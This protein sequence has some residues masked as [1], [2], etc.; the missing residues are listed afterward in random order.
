M[1]ASGVRRAKAAFFIGCKSHPAIAPAGSNRSSP[2]GDKMAEAFG[3]L[4]PMP[5][6]RFDARTRRR[7]PVRQQRTPGSVRG[8]PGARPA[9][10][11]RVPEDAA[12]HQRQADQLDRERNREH[13]ADP[14][15]AIRRSRQAF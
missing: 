12:Q 2:G 8:E 7:S 5:C 3:I 4:H 15:F 10:L 9:V 6:H 13:G 1:Y 14:Y 11:T